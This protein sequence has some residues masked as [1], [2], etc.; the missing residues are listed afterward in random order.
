MNE[1]IRYVALQ[2][3]GIRRFPLTRLQFIEAMLIEHG[4]IN[5]KILMAALGVEAAMSS[6]D[7]AQYAKINNTVTWNRVLKRWEKTADFK[8]VDGLLRVNAADYLRA[9][10]VVF[11][12]VLGEIPTTKTE[13]GVIK[14]GEHEHC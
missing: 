12:F 7:M 2:L 11:G 3:S 9:A 1:G 5:R 14:D 4:F 6:R 10:G 8:P 13:L